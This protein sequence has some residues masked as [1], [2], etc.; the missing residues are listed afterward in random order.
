MEIKSKGRYAVRVMADI[1][2]HKQDAEFVSVADIAARQDI[3]VKYLEHI[4][5]QLVGAGLLISQRGKLGGYKLSKLPK[6]YTIME[7]LKCTGERV[8]ISNC[9]KRPDCPHVGKCDTQGV[10]GALDSLISDYLSR[11]TLQDLLDRTYNK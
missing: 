7:I 6:E 4:I 5:A 8:Q 2:R 3:S 10:W 9:D 1:A 11:V